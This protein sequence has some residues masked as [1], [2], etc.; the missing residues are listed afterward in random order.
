MPSA[1][2][3][4][5]LPPGY[6]AVT[7]AT[8]QASQHNPPLEDIAAALTLRLS[9]DG[10]APMTGAIQFLPGTVTVPGAVFSTDLSSG[11]YKTTTGI[12]V[13][14]GG[15]QVAEFLPGGVNGARFI[16]E[17][18]PFT[19]KTAPALTVF[20]FGQTL[21][22][23]TYAALWTFAQNEINSGNNTFYNN[24]DGSTTFGIG[25]ARCRAFAGWDGMGGGATGRLSSAG[26]GTSASTLGA[27]GG[28]ETEALVAN[29][30]PVIT[31]GVSATSSQGATLFSP[32]TGFALTSF[33]ANAGAQVW[34]A[35]P[36]GAGI[37][38]QTITVSGS[39]TSNNTGSAAHPNVQ[40]TIIT[41]FLLFAGA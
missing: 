34:Q 10:T 36:P 28:L 37:V 19:G 20:P 31:S 9:R 6:L 7:G 29:Q 16:G 38:Q 32:V 24:G 1:N 33:S 12:G 5:S 8:I 25:D 13:A 39:A 3:V 21:S 22:R 4:Y 26:F 15:V 40:P 11:L 41:S 27:T 35:F 2:G 14:I 18:V 17:L 30:V 23:T